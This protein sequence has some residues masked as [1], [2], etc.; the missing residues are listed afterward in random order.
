ETNY[1]R[2]YYGAN[3]QRLVEIKR[4]YDPDNL[5]RFTQSIPLSL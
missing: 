2:A 1:L 4:K 3:L 5:F